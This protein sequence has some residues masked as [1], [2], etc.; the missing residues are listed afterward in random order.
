ML[1]STVI[2][3]RGCGREVMRFLLSFVYLEAEVKIEWLYREKRELLA[4]K[5]CWLLVAMRER[6]GGGR[7][8]EREGGRRRKK[9]REYY[10][11][12]IVA[13]GLP[14]SH[15]IFQTWVKF[16]V[17]KSAQTPRYLL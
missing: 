7:G 13:R 15:M 6:G 17:N 12:P 11:K 3:E 16:A 9:R 10:T 2:E 8:R 1:A 5:V 14:K 4:T